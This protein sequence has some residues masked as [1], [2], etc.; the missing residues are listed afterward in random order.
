MIQSSKTNPRLA[1]Q[2]ISRA[3]R[4][5]EEGR[6]SGTPMEQIVS[7]LLNNRQDWLPDGCTI[8]EALE[9]LMVV[10]E[11]DWFHTMMAIH[12]RSWRQSSTMY[13]EPLG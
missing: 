4:A 13:P 12:K 9:R 7:A 3:R 2:F 8:L 10:Y 5:A 6:A 11:E 1:V